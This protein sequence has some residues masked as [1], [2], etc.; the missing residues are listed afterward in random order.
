[1]T[2]AEVVGIGILL[3]LLWIGRELHK[4]VDVLS[5]DGSGEDASD[6]ADLMEAKLNA[7]RELQ[8]RRSKKQ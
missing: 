2:T 4:L 7:I 1:M 6:R 3:A 5:G 8:E